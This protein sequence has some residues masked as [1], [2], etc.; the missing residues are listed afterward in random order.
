MFI[1]WSSS[2]SN[3]IEIKKVRDFLFF[4]EVHGSKIKTSSFNYR[5]C[6]L[7]ILLANRMFQWIEVILNNNGKYGIL[8]RNALFKCDFSCLSS[9]VSPENKSSIENHIHCIISVLPFKCI[10]SLENTVQEELHFHTNST[11]YSSIFLFVHLANDIYGPTVQSYDLIS[12][13]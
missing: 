2:K 10:N 4:D 8:R 1:Q 13:V 9:N 12:T 11:D 5:T 6:V 7:N 3:K